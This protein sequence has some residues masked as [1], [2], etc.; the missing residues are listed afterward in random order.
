MKS[1]N[2]LRYVVQPGE[3]IYSIAWKFNNSIF[4]IMTMN[5]LLYPLVYPGQLLTILFRNA[6]Y[7][8]LQISS[9]KNTRCEVSDLVLQEAQN[10]NGVF[11]ISSP[12]GKI[13]VA[14]ML[15]DGVPYYFV[16]YFEKDIINPSKLG[17]RFKHVELNQNFIINDVKYGSFDQTWTQPWGEVKEIRNH[18]NEFLIELEKMNEPR[19]RMTI[20]FRVYNCGLGF[21]YVLPKQD[22]LEEFELIDE[23]TEFTLTDDHHAW[24]IPAYQPNR[25]EYLYRNS[26][27]STIS[28]FFRA[29]HTPLTMKT[30]DGL[31]LSI[32]EANLTNYASMTLMPLENYTLKADL[33]PWSDGIKVKG[34]TS[35][36]TPWRTI[37]LAK[38]PG[39]L[40][41]S[42]M[43]LNLNEPNKL[44][45]V[46]WVKPRKYIG[47]W[48][49]MHIEKYTWGPGPR[50]G[51]TT[52]N[53]KKYIDFAAK[54][55]IPMVLIEGWNVGWDEDWME[56]GERFD[57]T[58]PQEDFDLKEVASYAAKKGVKIMGHH[59][60]SSAIQNYE[61]QIEEAFALYKKLGIDTVKTGYVG[62]DPAIERRDEHGNLI[63]MEW[64][65]GQ[66]MVNHYKKVIETA[67]KYQIMLNVHEPIKDTGERR[68]YPN[69]MTREGA[70]GQEYN[71]WSPDGGNPPEHT[72][73]LPF[74]RMLSGPLDYTPGIFDLFIDEY[75]PDH[76]V[77]H[78]L[79][80]E[81]ALYVVLYSP[82]Q[83]LADL[84]ENH[85]KNL[86]AFKFL[87]DVPVDWEHTK[88]L[89]G[90]IGEY[91]TITRK[92]RNSEDWYLGSI[93]NENGR[94]LEVPLTFLDPCKKYIAEIYA[95]GA[96]ADWI[97]NPYSLHIYQVLVDSNTVLKIILANGGGQAIRFRPAK[98]ITS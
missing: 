64:H 29:V 37:Q 8:N 44:G 4:D 45:E 7:Q 60:T 51:A 24:W 61:Q 91:I 58:T 90:E 79:A 96:D 50:H 81:L 55:G 63:G 59:E 66:Y 62:D 88:V 47:I 12:D 32:H 52:E 98:S 9:T 38:Q 69:M 87:L 3:T 43:I 89:N 85:E 26:P 48:W 94:T 95:D 27:I 16:R 6:K 13:Q 53:T 41:T 42:Y 19:L 17:L 10:E 70:R 31:Y 77:Q 15:T 72:T 33:V 73:I 46:P 2:M 34:S 92:D 57:F 5:R 1:D 40:L 67:A 20:V 22:Q 93:T 30:A 97:T 80:K 54:Y 39:D 23:E 35:L 68:T 65:H 14:F 78:T 83:M 86:P 25:Y 18:Y 21:R 71:A 76:R 84:P 56:H 75:Q 11:C 28:K 74:T 82:L 49:G 36:I